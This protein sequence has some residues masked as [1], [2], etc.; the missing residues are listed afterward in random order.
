MG[1]SREQHS[2]ERKRLQDLLAQI[3]PNF[4]LDPV[5]EEALVEICDEFVENV[6]EFACDLARHRGGDVVE[7]QD[8]ELPLEKSWGIPVG[9]GGDGPGP[10]RRSEAAIHTH[11]I[12]QR[13]R[14]MRR[15]TAPIPVKV[16]PSAGNASSSEASVA[17]S[18][19]AANEDPSLPPA[20]PSA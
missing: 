13:D 14:V 20:S 3:S 19:R 2:V 4:E 10:V 16:Q 18:V 17:A 7:A 12:M 8:V 9:F 1:D 11:R 5:V 6:T 15:R